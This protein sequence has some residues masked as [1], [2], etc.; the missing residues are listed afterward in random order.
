LSPINSE[1]VISSR[2]VQYD[3][4]SLGSGKDVGLPGLVKVIP[5][6][7]RVLRG[8][9][10]VSVDIP[11]DFPDGDLRE[12]ETVILISAEERCGLLSC[13][14]FTCGLI[15]RHED[16]LGECLCSRHDVNFA[17]R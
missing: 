4:E 7:R 11:R 2:C 14:L 9:D 12:T 5:E 6:A 16:F 1:S 17:G 8:N 3:R 13:E 10:H 15:S